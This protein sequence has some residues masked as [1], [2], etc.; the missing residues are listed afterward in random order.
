MKCRLRADAERAVGL[1][2]VEPPGLPLG[3]ADVHVVEPIAVDVTHRER[4]AFRRQHMWNQRL[5]IEVGKIVLIVLEIDTGASRDVTEERLG[6]VILPVRVFPR[7]FA[8]REGEHL[9][10]LDVGE[11]LVATIRPDDGE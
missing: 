2:N 10:S 5:A 3:A 9:V 11:H 6:R 7:R 4:R 8:L 1:L